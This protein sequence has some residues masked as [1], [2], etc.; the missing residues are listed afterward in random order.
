MW[1][2]GEIILPNWYSIIQTKGNSYVGFVGQQ[3]NIQKG[4]PFLPQRCTTGE[5][6]C[7][8]GKSLFLSVF[9][10]GCV[11]ARR[12]SFSFVLIFVS[13]KKSGF[14]KNSRLFLP[15]YIFLFL[16]YRVANHCFK[17]LDGAHLRI[18]KIYFV[19]K[20]RCANIRL[21]AAFF[22]IFAH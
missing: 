15:S 2:T 9:D 5:T 7:R 12:K 14:H 22:H 3:S 21:V 16:L 20:A 4:P 17:L 13:K 18:G 10:T 8:A 11:A 6:D 19:M 1:G